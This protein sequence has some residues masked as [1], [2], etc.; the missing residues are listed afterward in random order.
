MRMSKVSRV[1]PALATRTLI[2]PCCVSTLSTAAAILAGSL[3]SNVTKQWR[4][5]LNGSKRGDNTTSDRGTYINQ[6]MAT[7]IPV[8]LAHPEWQNLITAGTTTVAQSVA[9][10]KNIQT[11]FNAIKSVPA[12][13]FAS[14]WTM[15]LIQTYELSRE[16]K[17]AG[18]PL[19]GFSIGGSM[20]ARGK[21]I[22][23]FAQDATNTLIAT[24]PFYAPGYV[25]F[26]AWITYKRKLFKNRIDWRLQMNVRNLLD[27]YT[28]T[29]LNTVDSRDGKHTPN[30]A[31]Y[32]LREPRT[33]QFTSTFKF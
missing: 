20:N 17:V 23:G 1:M 5:V 15:N 3:T 19:G 30:V 18:I 11:N 28:M 33:F 6:Y 32:T 29:P 26:G 22:D 7:Y 12:A 2:G 8:I 24:S 4:L 13:N 25:N 10:L 9:D 14:N 16:A 21:A 27:D 31:V